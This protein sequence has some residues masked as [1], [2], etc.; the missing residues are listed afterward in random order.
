MVLW[1]EVGTWNIG[2]LCG[3]GV[4]VYGELRRSTVDVLF[5]GG[6]ST[7]FYDFRYAW[8]AIYVVVVGK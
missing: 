4:E 8:N 6:D 5:A 7:G 2:S 3:I 1:L